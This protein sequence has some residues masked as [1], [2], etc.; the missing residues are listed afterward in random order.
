MD[1]AKDGAE[2]D[3]PG[4]A[5][6]SSSQA[7]TSSDAAASNASQRVDLDLV[8]RASCSCVDGSV[9]CQRVRGVKCWKSWSASQWPPQSHPI[10]AKA[11]ITTSPSRIAP[12][13]RPA[14]AEERSRLT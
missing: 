4:V 11:R 13:G 10:R 2:G 5:D 12:T 3:S 1:G 6:V 14:A 9:S 8:V 7:A